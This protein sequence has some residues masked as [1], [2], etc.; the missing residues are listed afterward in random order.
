ISTDF[1]FDGSASSPYKPGDDANPLS[2]Y[3]KSKYEGETQ[4]NNICNGKG[5]IIRSSWIYSS[6]GKNFVKT[7]LELMQKE[8]ELRV[9]CD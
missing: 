3:G 9:V 7:M 2:V 8:S 4:V 5:I 1:I 6:H